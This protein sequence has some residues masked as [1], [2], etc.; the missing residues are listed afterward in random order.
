MA[1]YWFLQGGWRD[2]RLLDEIEFGERV[3]EEA[4]IEEGAPG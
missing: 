1:G 4:A 2:K 3:R